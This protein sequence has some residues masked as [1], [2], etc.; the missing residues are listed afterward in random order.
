MKGVINPLVVFCVFFKINL[1]ENSFLYPLSRLKIQFFFPILYKQLTMPKSRSKIKK[2][3][4]TSAAAI[5]G[6]TEELESSLCCSKR[7]S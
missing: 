3:I 2:S 1:S 5:I 7:E 4:I 6:L